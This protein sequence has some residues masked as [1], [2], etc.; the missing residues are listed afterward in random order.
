LTASRGTRSAHPRKRLAQARRLGIG[1]RTGP[2]GALEERARQLVIERTPVT[3]NFMMCHPTWENRP[4]RHIAGAHARA[5]VSRDPRAWH[6]GTPNVSREIR[7]M[8][9]VEYGGRMLRR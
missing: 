5:G 8:P 4:I 9:N 2:D 3:I 6:G 1:L 7:A